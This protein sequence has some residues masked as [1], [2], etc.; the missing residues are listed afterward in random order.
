MNTRSNLLIANEKIIIN[1][2]S[3]KLEYKQ[4]EKVK[5]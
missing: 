2:I 4:T 5:L 1:T 3:I